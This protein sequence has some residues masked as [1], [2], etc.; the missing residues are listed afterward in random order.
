MSNILSLLMCS[1]DASPERQSISMNMDSANILFSYQDFKLVMALKELWL[2][3]LAAASPPAAATAQ[4]EDAPSEASTTAASN[5]SGAASASASADSVVSATASSSSSSS[6]MTDTEASSI[7]DLSVVADKP[8]AVK[9]QQHL[10]FIIIGIEL[11]LLNDCYE[12]EGSDFSSPIATFKLSELKALVE[13]WSD[14]LNG[15]LKLSNVEATYFNGD[16]NAEEPLIE[17]WSMWIDIVTTADT[18]MQVCSQ[19]LNSSFKRKSHMD[20]IN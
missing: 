19:Y 11:R 7:G 20:C 4:L 16:L 17:P 10:D 6:S 2:G 13:D 14:L 3:A 18:G 1:Y 5:A 12:G 8:A 15:N 9:Q